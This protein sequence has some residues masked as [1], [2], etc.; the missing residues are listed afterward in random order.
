MFCYNK[1]P[2]VAGADPGVVRS[3]PLKRNNCKYFDH[4]LLTHV[5]KDLLIK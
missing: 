1:V 3:N 4:T 2:I 5:K